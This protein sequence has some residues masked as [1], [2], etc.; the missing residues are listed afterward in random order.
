[1]S[2]LTAIRAHQRA[3]LDKR[4]KSALYDLHPELLY[5]EHLYSSIAGR[6]TQEADDY[7]GHANIY[8]TYIWVR[9]AITI[10]AQNLS[11]LPVRVVDANGKAVAGHPLTELYANPNDTM[12]G[13]EYRAIEVVYLLLGG[14]RF[15]EVVDDARGRPAELW[16]RRP[17]MVEIRPDESRK[18]YPAPAN[19]VLKDLATQTYDGTA[20]V[21][22]VIHEKF[23]NPLSDWRGLAPMTAIRNA[24]LLDLLA[25]AQS[26]LFYKNQARPDYAIEQP[27]ALAP[28][29]RARIEQQVMEKYGGGQSIGK[30]MILEAGQKIHVLSFP[31]KDLEGLEQRQVSRDEV[32]ALFGVPDILM[33]FGN[34][35]YDTEE[36]RDA[37]MS[38]LWALTLLPLVGQHDQTE[39]HFWSKVRP[40]LRNGEQIQTDLSSVSV[41]QEALGPKLEHLNQLWSKGVPFNVI[42]EALKLN[43]GRFPG[44]DVGWLPMNL[45]PVKQLLAP[46]EPAPPPTPTPAPAPAPPPEPEPEEERERGPK[47]P[48]ATKGR[49]PAA[50]RTAAS[51]QRIRLAVARRMEKA[52]D[53]YYE[54]LADDVVRRA[55]AVDQNNLALVS[56]GRNGRP[57]VADLTGLVKTLPTS[58]DLILQGDEDGLSSLFRSFALEVV[59]QSWETWNLSLGLDVVFEESDPAVVA[60]LGQS[61]SHIKQITETT[62]QAVKDLLQYGAEQGWTIDQLVRGDA[63]H[64]GLGATVQQTYKGRARTIARTET[65]GAQATATV[66]RFRSANV[67]KVI[68]FDGGSEDSDD[69]CNALDGTSQTLDWYQN[70]KL[71]HPNCVRAAGPDFDS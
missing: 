15:S 26:V 69:I 42:N 66:E 55:R 58:E 40:L 7:V 43:I 65:G 22:A 32:A 33:G 60:A 39:T 2:I 10:I 63:D 49:R 45:V 54:D 8:K 48:P 29:E 1:M 52:V 13:P 17:D 37:A 27:I 20:P 3:L 4:R 57:M 31:P 21:E 23:V 24:I 70:N 47:A 62:R 67:A 19:Y 28:N 51:L 68:I 71:Q 12:P 53:R 50:R 34:D 61:L 64:P 5:R 36:K 11:P 35:S 59:E 18:G 14:E 25:Q 16:P 56:P 30:P 6:I 44:D 46:P 9:K 38:V 41:L